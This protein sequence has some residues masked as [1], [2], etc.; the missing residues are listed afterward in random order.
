M[1]AEQPQNAQEQPGREPDAP[2]EVTSRGGLRLADM[3]AQH[4]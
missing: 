1:T 4:G 2:A 3:G